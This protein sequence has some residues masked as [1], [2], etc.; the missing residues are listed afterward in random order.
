[1]DLSQDHSDDLNLMLQYLYAG[2]YSQGFSPEANDA[3]KTRLLLWALGDRYGVDNLKEIAY[4]KF[5]TTVVGNWV[6]MEDCTSVPRDLARALYAEGNP[7]NDD[8]RCCLVRCVNK[9]GTQFRNE[10]E[11]RETLK[12]IPEFH[13]DITKGLS[14][15]TS[16]F[17]RCKMCKKWPSDSA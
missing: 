12:E 11:V 5:E 13:L 2:N 16:P 1:M 7:Y 17:C 8:M 14:R 9:R 10:T 15:N 3:P 4:N 6:N